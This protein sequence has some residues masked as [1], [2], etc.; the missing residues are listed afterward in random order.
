MS[1]SAI[2]PV[3][4]YEVS[5]VM[6]QVISTGLLVERFTAQSPDGIQTSTGAPSGNF[7]NVA[8]LVN[9]P[10]M[11]SVQ[12][13]TGIAPTEIR[14][15]EEIL[16]RAPRHVMLNADYTQ[17]LAGWR[18]GWRAVIAYPDGTVTTYIIMGVETDSQTTHSRVEVSEVSL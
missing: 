15:L 13:N 12:S 1:T 6:K 16:A 8:G 11:S 17:L 18:N 4:L 3:L 2:P 5:Q 9:I 10:C 14:Q 7:A